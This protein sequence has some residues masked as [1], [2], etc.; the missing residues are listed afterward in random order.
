MR[1]LLSLSLLLFS[2]G[3]FAQAPPFVASVTPATGPGSGG[4]EVTIAGDHLSL[5]PN[6]ACLL[7]CPAQVSFGGAQAQLLQ[8]IDKELVVR[9]PP[10]GAGTVD[11]TVRTGDGRTAIAPGA[12][13]YTDDGEERYQ[14]ILLP[15]YLEQPAHGSN[16][17]LW[18]TQLWLRN[19]GTQPITLA[20]WVCPREMICIPV[21]PLTYEMRTG[22]TLKNLPEIEQTNVG[23]LLYVNRDGLAGLSAGLRLFE[24]SRGD[25]DAGTEIP[26]VRESRF[27]TGTSH[28]HAVPLNDRFRVMLRVYEMGVDDAKFLVTVV[29]ESE[30]MGGSLP[31]AQFTLRTM[32]AESGTFREH[33]GY[34]E[35]GA[36][37]PM[38]ANARI[39]VVPLTAGSR[40]WA[41]VSI[42][43]NDTQR[44]TLVTP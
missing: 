1:R 2:S 6:F 33:P 25:E 27:A 29:E 36:F 23:R 43:S 11:I 37:S 7:P 21:F 18:K 42:T 3:V 24:T 35:Y 4:T 5:P 22:E 31:L 17:S 16:G 20:P 39:D 44:V 8:E 30:G 9:T 13:V 14:R 19:G 32:A 34:A 12:F 41:L 10:H 28:F 15:I 38:P 26:V 40:Y